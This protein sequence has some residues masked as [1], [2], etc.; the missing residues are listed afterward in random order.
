MMPCRIGRRLASTELNTRWQNGDWPHEGNC[1]IWCHAPSPAYV[2]CPV[3][4]SPRARCRGPL[5]G[6][7]QKD[8]SSRE[9]RGCTV[10]AG[11]ADQSRRGISTETHPTISSRFLPSYP[12]HRNK[13]REGAQDWGSSRGSS[14]KHLPTLHTKFAWK[15]PVQ[16]VQ[17]MITHPFL[18]KPRSVESYTLLGEAQRALLFHQRK[19]NKYLFSFGFSHRFHG[20]DPLHRSNSVEHSPDQWSQRGRST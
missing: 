17:V 7:H 13:K 20:V 9:H 16:R 19:Y 11:H 6:H 10:T 5:L 15:G 14:L 4:R 8:W 3:G 2:T 1:I 12:S 18:S